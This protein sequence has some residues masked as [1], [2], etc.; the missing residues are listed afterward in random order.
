M[1]RRIF[2]NFIDLG[3]IVFKGKDMEGIANFGI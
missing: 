2:R 1:Y 3:R